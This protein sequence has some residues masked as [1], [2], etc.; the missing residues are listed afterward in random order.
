MENGMHM[1]SVTRRRPQLSKIFL[2][3]CLL[4]APLELF[5]LVYASENISKRFFEVQQMN[6]MK[7]W[8]SND[9]GRFKRSKLKFTKKWSEIQWTFF[10][11]VIILFTFTHTVSPM[12]HTIHT[13]NMYQYAHAYFLLYF[14]IHCEFVY[15]L[16]TMSLCDI[17]LTYIH[18]YMTIHLIFVFYVL[19]FPGFRV[20]R[21]SLIITSFLIHLLLGNYSRY[22]HY[23][24]AW[25]K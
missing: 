7:E 15:H 12:Q 18:T 8:V 11:T 19:Y 3:T 10:C 17:M 2:K 24:E 5:N 21:D 13:L 14:V 6:E 22:L 9:Y 16:F 4:T 1:A 20:I 25:P 23:C